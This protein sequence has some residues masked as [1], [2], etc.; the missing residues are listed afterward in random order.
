MTDE[1]RMKKLLSR[2]DKLREKQLVALRKGKVKKYMRIENVIN[3]AMSRVNNINSM[4]ISK[5]GLENQELMSR[6][7]EVL[8][9]SEIKM[10]QFFDSMNQSLDENT[11]KR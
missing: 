6:S 7:G 9:S 11:P 4:K 10:D 3:D 2:I 1:A 5:L 8:D